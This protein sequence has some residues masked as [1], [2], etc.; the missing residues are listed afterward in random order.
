MRAV[1][2][3]LQGNVVYLDEPA[4]SREG[5]VLVLIPTETDEA[6]AAILALAGVW[7]DMTDEEWALLQETLTQGATSGEFRGFS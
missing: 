5:E 7:S 4:D 3:R 2:G 1:K 6:K